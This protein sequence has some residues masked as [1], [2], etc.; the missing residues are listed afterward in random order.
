MIFIII[1]IIFADGAARGTRQA[2]RGAPQGGPGPSLV[3]L[4]PSFLHFHPYSLLSY[5]YFLY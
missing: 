3:P 1:K 2:Q 4:F 5:V